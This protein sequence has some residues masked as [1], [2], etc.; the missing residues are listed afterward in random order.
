MGQFL[1]IGI[2]TI[3]C[4]SKAGAKRESSSATPEKI[5]EALESRFNRN[6]IYNVNENDKCV[7]L[8]LRPELA[9]AELMDLLH[10]FYAMRYTDR[11]EDIAEM[12]KDLKSH[13]KWIEWIEIANKKSYCYFQEDSYVFY[14]TPFDGGWSNSLPTNIHQ[15]L[16]S[17][18]GKI[19]MECWCGLFEFFTRL[20]KEKLSKYQ[21][22]D[23]LLVAISG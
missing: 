2:A 6:G 11:D 1:T 20:I 23:S 14:P 17:A 10:D 16:L 9:E 15:I 19:T 12:M 22:S 5:R 3:I 8:S 7:Y 21:L 18:D 4:I 13:T